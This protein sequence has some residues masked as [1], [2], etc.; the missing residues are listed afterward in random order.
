MMTKA[1]Y[2]NEVH[3]VI[4]GTD[5][6]DYLDDDEITKLQLLSSLLRQK[7]D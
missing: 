7:W 2:L 6:F 1:P 4:D 5:V 3:E